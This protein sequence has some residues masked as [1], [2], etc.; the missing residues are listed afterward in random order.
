MTWKVT[1]FEADEMKI[2]LGF[3]SPFYISKYADQDDVVVHIKDFRDM[4]VSKT[5]L[6]DLHINYT[7][8]RCRVPKQMEDTAFSR[9]MVVTAENVET[10]ITASVLSSVAFN[11]AFT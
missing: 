7:T 4:F 1:R 2:S 11:I 10:L 9:S 6:T 5:L 3:H 8:L